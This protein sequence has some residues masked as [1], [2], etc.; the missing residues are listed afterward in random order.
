MSYTTLLIKHV[1]NDRKGFLPH[2]LPQSDEGPAEMIHPAQVA[3]V[4]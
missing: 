2:R 3:G 1:V 4:L